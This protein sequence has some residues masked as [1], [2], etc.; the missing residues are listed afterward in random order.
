MTSSGNAF[1][2]SE[3]SELLVPQMLCERTSHAFTDR[4]SCVREF[5]TACPTNA[6][7]THESCIH[8]P[9][10]SHCFCDALCSDAAASRFLIHFNLSHS[11]T[12]SASQLFALMLASQAALKLTRDIS[13]IVRSPHV[14]TVWWVCSTSMYLVLNTSHSHICALGLIRPQAHAIHGHYFSPFCLLHFD[15]KCKQ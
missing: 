8:R 2:V 5:R 12:P 9:L 6:L 3:N 14:P 15:S 7:R 13:D 1:P 4:L 11:P 10:C